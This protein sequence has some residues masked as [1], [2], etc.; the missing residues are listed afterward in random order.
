[1]ED[2]RLYTG[3]SEGIPVLSW[4]LNAPQKKEMDCIVPKLKEWTLQYPNGL[5]F[6]QEIFY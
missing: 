5:L 1:M 6:L 2:L 4:N 3:K